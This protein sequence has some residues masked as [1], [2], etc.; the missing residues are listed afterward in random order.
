V[1]GG[2][3]LPLLDEGP[4]VYLNVYD[5]ADLGVTCVDFGDTVASLNRQTLGLWEVGFFHSGVEISGIEYSFGSAESGSGVYSCEPRQAYGARFRCSIEMGRTRFTPR[6][7]R[8]ELARYAAS[9]T[10]ASYSLLTRNCCHFCASVC[11]SLG[12]APVPKWVNGLADSAAK[13]VA[14]QSNNLKDLTRSGRDMPPPPPPPTLGDRCTRCCYDDD[15]TGTTTT[16]WWWWDSLFPLFGPCLERHDDGDD[17]KRRRIPADDDED[18]D[19]HPLRLH[20]DVV[21]CRR[22]SLALEKKTSTSGA[23]RCE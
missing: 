22:R 4:M 20:H 15:D 13:A 5:L 9:W 17:D 14:F 1:W 2:S 21:D 6:L 18:D 19:P 8:L 11:D 10:G 12:V 16:R 7:V 3:P 23:P